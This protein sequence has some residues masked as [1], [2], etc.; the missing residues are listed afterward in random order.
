M[1]HRNA[2]APRNTR[3]GSTAPK[4]DIA[5]GIAARRQNPADGGT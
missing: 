2:A 5:R 3:R 1:R 4:E